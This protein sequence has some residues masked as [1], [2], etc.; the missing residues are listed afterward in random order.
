MSNNIS[1]N[2]KYLLL[3]RNSKDNCIRCERI[4]NGIDDIEDNIISIGGMVLN[5]YQMNNI[6]LQMSIIKNS[7][8]I[9]LDYGSSFF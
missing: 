6:E 2:N 1:F 4:I 3:P 8:I 5:T 7:E 9:I